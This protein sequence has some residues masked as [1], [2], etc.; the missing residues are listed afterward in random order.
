MSAMS[1]ISSLTRQL[2][3]SISHEFDVSRTKIWPCVHRFLS[4]FSSKGDIFPILDILNIL[5][6]GCGNG[7]NMVSMPGIRFTGIDFCPEFVEICRKKGLNVM[8]GDMR[9]MRDIKDIPSSGYDGFISVASYH[10]LETDEDRKKALGEM[11]RILKKGGRGLIVVW[12]KEQESDSRFVFNSGVKTSLFGWDERVPWKCKN[13]EGKES[14]ESKESKEKEIKD[15]ERYY[16]VY[17]EGDLV[18]EVNSLC[19]EFII[20]SIE[21]EKGNWIVHPR[22]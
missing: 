15:K 11:Y 12:A 9:E 13:K 5:D 19:P 8:E 16:H 2:Y 10:H 6:I 20:E 14:K 22:K 3:S 1:V 4:L 18:G 21:W 7:K 17:G